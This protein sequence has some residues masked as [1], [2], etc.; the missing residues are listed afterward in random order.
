MHLSL[1]QLANLILVAFLLFL[2]LRILWMTIFHPAN[3]PASWKEAWRT[4]RLPARLVRLERF[5]PDKMRFFAMWL[6]VE[7]LQNKKVQGA[8]AEL[9]VYR[10][11]SARLLHL[12]DPSRKLFL[13]DTFEGFPVE[14]LIPE[15]GLPATYTTR[16]FADTSISKVLKKIDGNHLIEVIPGYFPGSATALERVTFALV[17]I[18]AD[19][20]NPT[21]AGLEFFYP[22]LNRGGV[23]L[24]HDYNPKWPGV[25]RATDEFLSTIPEIPVLIP[26]R[27][28]TLVIVKSERRE[29]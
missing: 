4:K 10:G 16:N 26:D 11:E 18:D 9:G 5:Y 7:R 3:Q 19:L 17:N 28:G 27:D 14:D 8:F 13:L 20:Y 2:S 12:M 22:K 25:I 15:T 1:F 24:V 29:T 21:K 6:Q 23:I